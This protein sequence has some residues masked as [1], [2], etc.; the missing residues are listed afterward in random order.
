MPERLLEGAMENGG[1]VDVRVGVLE[2]APALLGTRG[3][4]VIRW[5]RMFPCR[6]CRLGGGCSRNETR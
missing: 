5:N 3:R 4:R 1:P 6:G 2:R